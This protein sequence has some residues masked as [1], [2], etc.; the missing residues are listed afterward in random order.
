MIFLGFAENSIQLVPDGTLFLHIAIIL[1]MVFVLDHTLFKPINRILEEREKRTR[2]RSGE[3]RDIL[4]RVEESTANYERSLREA[5]AEGY[6]LMEQVREEAMH[7]RQKVLDS[8]REEVNRSIMEQ[9][10][11]IAAQTEDA[12]AVLGSDAMRIGREIG[13]RILHR[14]ISEAATTGLGSPA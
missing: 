12:R 13:E 10:E 6:R 5:R 2:G 8:I 11:A 3:A 4:L 14:P 9:K 7:E 1:V